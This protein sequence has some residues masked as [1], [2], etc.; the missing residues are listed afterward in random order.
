MITREEL[1]ELVWNYPAKAAAE[2]VG[3]CDVHLSRVCAALMVPRPPRGWWARRCRP[4][5][6]PLGPVAPGFRDHWIVDDRGFPPIKRLARLGKV[7]SA[8]ANAGI[9]PVVYLAR[10]I[11]RAANESQDGTHLVTRRLDAIDLTVSAGAL[12]DGLSLASELFKVLE[13]RGHPVRVAAEQGYIRPPLDNWVGPLAYPSG[14]PQRLWAPKAPTLTVVY[15]IPIG[16]AVLE[17]AEEVL[18]RYMGDGEFLR[19]SKGGQVD[20]ITWTEWQRQPTRRFKI[21]AYSPHF[22]APWQREWAETRR[23]SL[24]RTVRAVVDE[25]EA[26]ALTLPHAPFFL[27]SQESDGSA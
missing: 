22:P 11:F 27:R 12:D 5:P 18:M 20:G 15:G 4:A 17:I 10:K 13:H 7:W 14:K 25:L 9:H 2:R 26:T 23:N 24:V 1:Y 21:V 19:A 6:P 16:L 3:I 8:A